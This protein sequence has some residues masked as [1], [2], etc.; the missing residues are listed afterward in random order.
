MAAS[1][2]LTL[3]KEERVSSKLIIDRLFN[4][5]GSRSMAAFPIRLVYMKKERG[6]HEPEAQLLISVPKRCFKLAV[7][8][9]RVKRQ[10]REAYRHH[11]HLISSREGV[12]V[13]MAFIWLDA[14]LYES[15]EVD[16][17]VKSL[18]MRME[19]RL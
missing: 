5:G 12:S 11:K 17:R 6:E 8:R 19:E 3:K 4:G 16:K 1:E 9:N 13:V 14:K 2:A 7:H 18:L 10:I 15:N